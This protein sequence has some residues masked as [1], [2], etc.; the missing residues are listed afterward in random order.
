M[1]IKLSPTSDRL[2]PIVAEFGA[3]PC[4]ERLLNLWHHATRGES[5]GAP[6]PTEFA[7]IVRSL[8]DDSAASLYAEGADLEE[9]VRAPYRWIQDLMRAELERR[10]IERRASRGSDDHSPIAIPHPAIEIRNEMQF[11]AYE[12]D[13]DQIHEALRGLPDEEIAELLVVTPDHIESLYSFS[14]NQRSAIQVAVAVLS[15]RKST[16]APVLVELRSLL[17]TRAVRSSVRVR[18]TTSFLAWLRRNVGS[19]REK[20]ASAAV[21]RP[22]L[23]SKTTIRPK[24]VMKR[25][26][27]IVAT[28]R[29]VAR[30]Q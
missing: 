13:S 22:V 25:V 12:F 16:A 17:E 7:Q 3:N 5:A 23:G 6:L 8:D 18:N 14:S 30:G 24:R 10:M 15:G 9:Q 29:E 21:H 19:A 26:D 11:A 4:L 27:P 1:A 2:E 28:E 20:L